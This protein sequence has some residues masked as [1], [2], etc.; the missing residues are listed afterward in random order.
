MSDFLKVYASLDI[1]REGDRER[2][3]RESM[4]KEK[5]AM[6]QSGQAC[7][8]SPLRRREC[9][10][11][12][13]AEAAAVVASAVVASAAAASLLGSVFKRA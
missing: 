1:R 8:T 9:A 6:N 7:M 10:T 4:E 13:T 3:A 12:P 2:V 5:E 11:G